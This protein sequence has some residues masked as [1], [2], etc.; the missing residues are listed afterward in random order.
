MKR[1]KQSSQSFVSFLRVL[2]IV[3]F[4]SDQSLAQVC[5][6]SCTQTAIARNRPYEEAFEI[7]QNRE[8]EDEDDFGDELGDLILRRHIRNKRAPAYAPASAPSPSPEPDTMD[9]IMEAL[10][11]AAAPAAA[12]GL[13][14]VANMVMPMFMGSASAPTSGSAPLNFSGPQP[15]T[16]GGGFLPSALANPT[17]IAGTSLFAALSLV[18]AGPLVALFD[19]PATDP[20]KAAIAGIFEEGNGPPSR[21]RGKREVKKQMILFAKLLL[22]INETI[23]K[24][25][26]K[27]SRYIYIDCHYVKCF[28]ILRFGFLMFYGFPHTIFNILFAFDKITAFSHANY[29][30]NFKVR[31]LEIDRCMVYLQTSL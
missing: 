3:L 19:L 30:K 28:L 25:Q 8:W 12:A 4:K 18:G 1:T 31:I 17:V 9:G 26:H 2:T 24:G 23:E 16:P 27:I 20:N 6:V 21:R 22:W 29:S 11:M 10:E 13:I 14:G 5:S 7:I 15:G